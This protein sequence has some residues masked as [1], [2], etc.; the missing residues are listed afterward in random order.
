MILAARVIVTIENPG[1]V[2]VI[3]GR[4]YGQRAVIK[5]SQHTGATQLPGRFTP[6][7]FT[8]QEQK[9]FLEPRLLILTDPRTD[10]QP[11]VESSYVS[12]PTICFC[13]TDNELQYVDIAIPANN[14]GKFAIGLMYWLLAREVRRMRSLLPR[15]HPWEVSV[16]LFFFRDPSEIEEQQAAQAQRD[17][18]D[19]GGLIQGY[20]EALPQQEW[21]AEAAP[22]AGGGVAQ[23]WAADNQAPQGQTAG[24]FGAAQP[25]QV[26]E[27][28]APQNTAPQGFDQP[29]GGYGG[30]QQQ[31]A[32]PAQD[33]WGAAPAQQGFAAPAGG[34]TFAAP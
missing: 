12:I 33:Q 7:T 4:P 21:N 1:D 34:D 29:Q 13:D 15:L 32:A 28:A 8:N 23:E 24:G 14:K 31:Q 22:P 20:E 25:A 17:A 6:G 19:N 3:S 2:C 26:D 27:W 18:Q 16:D 11:L 9:Q 30:F 10:S 5:F